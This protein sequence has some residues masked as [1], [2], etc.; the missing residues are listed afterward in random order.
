MNLIVLII[1]FKK[2]YVFK[3]S[4]NIYEIIDFI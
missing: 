3:N 2:M 4:F 1:L